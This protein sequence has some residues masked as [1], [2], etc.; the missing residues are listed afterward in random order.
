VLRQVHVEADHFADLGDELRVDA[1]LPRL[2]RCGFSPKAR[3]I[4]DTDDCDRPVSSAIEGVDQCVSC[5]RPFS[6]RTRVTTTSTCSSVILRG[7]PG[8]G[9]SASPSIQS[10]MNRTR[11]LR[12][13]S[14][15]TPSRTETAR[16]GTIPD[17]SAQASTIRARWARDCDAVRLRP[18]PQAN[19]ARPRSFT[20]TEVVYGVTGTEVTELPEYGV[21]P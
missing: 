19:R 5:P 11:H 2:H 18:A 3:Q 12:T 8:R 7:A 17:S 21:S 10:A 15:D 1:Q 9:T 14:R 4:R 20:S 16:Q 6:V 13:I